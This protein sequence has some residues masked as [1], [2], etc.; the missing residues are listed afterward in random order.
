[1]TKNHKQTLFWSIGVIAVIGALIAFLVVQ[2][3]KPGTYDT[4]AQCLTD[5]GAKFYGAFWCPHCQAQKAMFGKSAKLIPYVECS[6]PDGKGQLQVCIDQGIEG[7]PTWTF[8]DGTRQSGKRTLEEL[9]QKT[10]CVIDA[11]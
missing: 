8:A 5:S 1:M 4:F 10:S 11:Q 3:K 2:A 7:Y 6:Q 9:A